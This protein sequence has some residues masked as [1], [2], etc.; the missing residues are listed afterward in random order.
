MQGQY[1]DLIGTSLA[2]VASFFAACVGLFIRQMSSYAKMH[3][4]MSPMAF[5]LG[6]VIL[7][8]MFL[9]FKVIYVPID[10]STSHVMTEHGS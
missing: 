5:T 10:P 7:C 6:S 4:L 3:F 1:D 2:L 8:P 9:A